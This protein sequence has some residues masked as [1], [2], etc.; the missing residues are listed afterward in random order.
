MLWG[1]YPKACTPL[2][3]ILDAYPDLPPDLVTVILTQETV[4]E[5]A[6]SLS[7]GA[8]LGGTDLISLQHWMLYFDEARG[9]YGRLLQ[10]LQMGWWI[11]GPM[12]RLSHT[13][14]C[15]L[16]PRQQAP[17][18]VACGG[19]RN[20]E[21]FDGEVCPEGGWTGGKVGVWDRPTLWR[22][23]GRHIGGN[24]HYALP[25]AAWWPG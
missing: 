4:I 14:V 3:S 21:V 20:L 16:G 23:R 15:S 5:V 13:N 7:G 22:D 19:R 10:S 24:P 12:G 2:A 11:S 18:S 1:K 6:L 8:G 17:S 9:E 25:V